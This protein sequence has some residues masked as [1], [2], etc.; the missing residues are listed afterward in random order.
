MRPRLPL[1][2]QAWVT[3]PVRQWARTSALEAA[4]STLPTT[5]GTTHLGF[6]FGV[7]VGVGLGAG[8]PVEPSIVNDWET[9]RAAFQF[10]LPGCDAVMVQVPAPAMC[11]VIPST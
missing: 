6:G 5:F 2:D 9:F 1:D 11:T 10:E 3:V 8:A 7:G 4:E